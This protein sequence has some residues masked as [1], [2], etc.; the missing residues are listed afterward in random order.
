MF[1]NNI[2]DQQFDLKVLIKNIEKIYLDLKKMNELTKLLLCDLILNFSHPMETEDLVK[3]EESNII[4]EEF[5][6]SD[7][8]ELIPYLNDD[9]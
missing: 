1:Q 2:A 8:L 6:I 7:H 9:I 4:S 5:K 3:V